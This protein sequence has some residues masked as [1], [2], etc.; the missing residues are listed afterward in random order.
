ME[1]EDQARAVALQEMKE[2]WGAAP[3]QPESKLGANEPEQLKPPPTE[4]KD[5]ERPNKW[6][7]GVTG[8]GPAG[9]ACASKQAW[10]RRVLWT[11]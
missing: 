9:K 4:E 8:E 2:V 10:R 5:A 11:R 1:V 6:I 3:P 7:K